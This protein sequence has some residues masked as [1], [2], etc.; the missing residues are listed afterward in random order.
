MVDDSA[1]QPKE[2]TNS[3]GVIEEKFP[4]GQVRVI[5]TKKD[6]RASQ[7]EK[8]LSKFL[9]VIEQDEVDMFNL[10]KR[11]EVKIKTKVYVEEKPEEWDEIEMMDIDGDDAPF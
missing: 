9:E 8:A 7:T 4:V 10:V 2:T 5:R 6:L 3:R 1:V 11:K